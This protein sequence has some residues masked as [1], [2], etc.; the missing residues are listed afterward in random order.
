MSDADPVTAEDLVVLVERILQIAFETEDDHTAA[1]LELQTLVADPDISGYIYYSH[2]HFD[3]EPN[4]AEI[5]Q[6][7]LDYRPIALGSPADSDR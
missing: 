4:A 7:A 6:R 5:V 2:L 1:V 3:H